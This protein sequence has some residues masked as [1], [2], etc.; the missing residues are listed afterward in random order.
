VPALRGHGLWSLI[1]Y[2]LGQRVPDLLVFSHYSRWVPRLRVSR[3]HLRDLI[4]FGA[5]TTDFRIVSCVGQYVERTRV[6]LFLGRAEIRLTAWRAKS[7]AARP[8]H[9]PESQAV[10]S[11]PFSRAS[12]KT[13][14][15]S[16]VG[17]RTPRI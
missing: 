8:M 12:R 6:D 15:F 9:S 4:H 5:N 16:A 1:V 11:C 7:S 2:Q 3:T 10:L 14:P 17:S 13:V